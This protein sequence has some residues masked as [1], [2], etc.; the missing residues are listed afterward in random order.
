VTIVIVLSGGN[1]DA[2]LFAELV[3]SSCTARNQARLRS[4]TSRA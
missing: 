3:A 2:E 1:V 4:A